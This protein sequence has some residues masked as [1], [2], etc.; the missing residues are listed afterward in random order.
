MTTREQV[1]AFAARWHEE[2]R[3]PWARKGYTAPGMEHDT[4]NPKTVHEGK[5][6][7]RVDSGSSGAFMVRKADG[8]VF[9]IKGY[10]VPN[11]RKCVGHVDE[12]CRGGKP[13][14]QYAHQSEFGRTAQ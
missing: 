9:C 10:G 11:L 12:V 1:E 5:T 4:Y 14:N 13:I 6:W 8:L 3:E 7:F 2:Q